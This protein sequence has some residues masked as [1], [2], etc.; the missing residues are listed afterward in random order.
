MRPS[1]VP[2]RTWVSL[3]LVL[4]A[5]T[6]PATAAVASTSP[7][8]TLPVSLSPCGSP[9]PS[10]PCQADPAQIQVDLPTDNSV[11]AVQVSWVGD[12]RRPSSAPVPAKQQVVLTTAAGPESPV[13]CQH[14]T[15]PPSGFAAFCWQWPASLDYP[16]G[17]TEWLLNG[18]Y[19]V[20]PCS[21]SSAS[22]PCS[23]STEFN[24]ALTEV[25]VAPS[26]PT[27]MSAQQSNG[28]VTVTWRPGPEPDLVGYTISRN[29]QTVYTC[30][31]DG[32]GPG[33]ATACANP[34]VFY[35]RP[36]SGTWRYSVSSLRFG[37]DASAA[38][39]VASPAAPTSLDVPVGPPSSSGG[40]S[41]P[42]QTYYGSPSPGH[43][44]VPPL[45]AA[46]T[47]RPAG[48]DGFGGVAGGAVPSLANAEGAGGGISGSPGGMS[49]ADDPALGGPL[50]SGTL[51]R[52][53]RAAHNV[54]VAAELAIAVLALALAV[55]AW[56]LRGELRAASVRVA[57]RRAASG[58]AT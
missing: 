14:P 45:P 29:D 15:P 16:S 28:S 53:Q 55:H 4:A 19:R 25:A 24:S 31:T 42:G 8:P 17:G 11:Q 13:A 32:A 3:G 37:A 36:G 27:G 18:T 33:A 5:V 57:A 9:T 1:S 58:T 39:V 22:T 49:Y 54:D 48:F 38:H 35:D 47:M 46:G 21:A 23:Y 26:V 10:T 6:W 56:Y 2:G 44:I 40:G 51:L 41:T 43:A 7:P 12:P 50:A 30:T 34:P 20:T 52:Q